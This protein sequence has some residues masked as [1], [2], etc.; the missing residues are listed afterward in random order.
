MADG[1]VSRANVDET[2]ADLLQQR[3]APFD[4]VFLLR[5]WRA[6][7]D[8]DALAALATR[9]EAML[10]APAERHGSLRA[11]AALLA[12]HVRLG[13]PGAARLAQ[14]IDAGALGGHRLILEGA[15]WRAVGLGAAETALLG[16][17]AF[18]NGLGTAAVRLGILGALAQQRLLNEIRPLMAALAAAPLADDTEP[19]SF[20]PLAE[21]AL[22]RQPLREHV[23]FST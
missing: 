13:T 21:I 10:F 16:A 7:D 17:Y 20:N 18:V 12:A 15:L 14:T 4:R 3:W 6:A 9:L 8:I 19:S 22:M 5:A 11:G 2:I 23:L 1:R